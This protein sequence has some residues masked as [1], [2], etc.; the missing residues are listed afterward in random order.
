MEVLT[1][2]KDNDIPRANC[3]HHATVTMKIDIRR[4]LDTGYLD[5]MV[6]GN[7]ALSK[8]NITNKMQICISG[9]TEADCIKNLIK[10]LE[11]M[12]DEER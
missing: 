12:N 1:M 6:L 5:A 8:Y 10:M 7:D 4:M 2:S 3:P 11:K 9:V